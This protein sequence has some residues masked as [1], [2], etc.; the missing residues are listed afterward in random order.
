M[1]L[2]FLKLEERSGL[3]V[4]VEDPAATPDTWTQDFQER[5]N[6]HLS[7]WDIGGIPDLSSAAT[8][9]STALPLQVG[10]FLLL[11]QDSINAS[12]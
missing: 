7:I 10:P 3:T 11:H 12:T 6:P 9:A 4:V 1:H 2:Y 5:V 8:S